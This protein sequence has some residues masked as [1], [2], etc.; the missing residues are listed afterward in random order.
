MRARRLAKEFLNPHL[1]LRKM[2]PFAYPALKLVR[3][4]KHCADCE[5]SLAELK[6]ILQSNSI[7]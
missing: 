1:M 5:S 2:T 4:G 6:A 7:D 3:A